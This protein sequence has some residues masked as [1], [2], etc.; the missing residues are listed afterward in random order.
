M[1]D[2]E[3]DDDFL[4]KNVISLIKQR[5]SFFKSEYANKFFFHIKIYQEEDSLFFL[6]KEDKVKFKLPNNF[7]EIYDKIYD[8]ISSKYIY[9]NNFNYYPFKQLIHVDDKSTY[10]TEIQ[11]K[12]IIYLLLNLDNG[13]EK[14]ELIKKIWPKDKDIFVNKLDT[15]LTNLKNQM[16]KELNLDLKFR[17]KS[18]IL[19][20]S[21]N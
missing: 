6:I 21:I 11:N 14:I 2:I 1:I 18:G 7:N 17:S 3:C 10:L 20:L 13:I 5:G 12:I 15:H 8:L 19:K 4:K 9:L 16:L